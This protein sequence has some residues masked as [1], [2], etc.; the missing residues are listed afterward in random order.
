MIQEKIQLT[1]GQADGYVIPLGLANLVFVI[2]DKGMIGCGAFDVMALDKFN[3]PAARVRSN[4][5]CPIASINDLLKG[6]IRD[7]NIAATKQGIKIGISGR[8]ALDH[9]YK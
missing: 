9:M 2:T 3:Y 6:I 1:H 4:S 5:G 7:S 8:E